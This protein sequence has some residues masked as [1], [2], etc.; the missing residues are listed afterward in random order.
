MTNAVDIQNNDRLSGFG[1]LKVQ[2]LTEIYRG[3]IKEFTSKEQL[4]PIA[5]KYHVD[6][7]ALNDSE[8]ELF[9]KTINEEARRDIA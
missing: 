9:I 1:V 8:W 4:L 7:S 2:A 3:R 6:V 5:R